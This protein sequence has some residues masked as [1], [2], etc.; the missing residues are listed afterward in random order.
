MKT[1]EQ[2]RNELS[3]IKTKEQYKDYLKIIDNLVD[4]PEEIGRAHV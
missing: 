3:P 4:C 2:I 1:L